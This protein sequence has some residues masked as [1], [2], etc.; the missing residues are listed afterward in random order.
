M[1]LAR[2]RSA[3]AEALW[4]RNAWMATAA[5]MAL[6]N[7]VLAAWLVRVD[8]REKT[9][10]TPPTLEKSF[11]VHGDE[12]SPEY[13]EQMALFF[14]GLA[15]TYHPDNVDEQVR[16][17][18]RYADPTVYGALAARLEAD[19]KK[20]RRNNLSSVFYPQAVRIEG[21][22]VLLTG[23]L[24][25]FIGQKSVQARQGVFRFRF[26]YRGGRLFVSEFEEVDRATALDD[27][28]PAGP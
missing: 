11:W 15:L 16:L 17:F 9:I 22:G 24:A 7:L 23:Q 14:A 2:Y 20:V 26:D 27:A 8:V 19:V 21:R 12:V 3:L 18:L 6:S 13:L 28:R 5:V 25:T 10:V 4:R 1:M